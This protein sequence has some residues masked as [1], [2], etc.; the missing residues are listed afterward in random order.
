MNKQATTLIADLRSAARSEG[1]QINGSGSFNDMQ[2]RRR[3]VVF[4]D[5]ADALE[6]ALASPGDGPI[7][8]DPETG[9]VLGRMEGHWF[10]EWVEEVF[11]WPPQPERTPDA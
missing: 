7:A 11:V 5:L 4:D 1:R 8:L 6:A 3:M 10:R 2:R 9:A